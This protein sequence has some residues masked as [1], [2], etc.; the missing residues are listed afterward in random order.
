MPQR[1]AHH[2]T[3]KR[4]LVKD[5]W[6]ITHDPLIVRYKGLRLFIDLAAEKVRPSEINDDVGREVAIE[7]K[8]FSS[9]SLVSDFEK[10][11]G[12]YSLYRDMLVR[13]K[14]DHEL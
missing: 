3:V 4:A 8:V 12:Q 1:D 13:A 5:G 9:I 10:A 6:T 14:S 2:E 7:V 11:V